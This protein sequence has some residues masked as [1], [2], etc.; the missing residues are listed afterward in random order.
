MKRRVVPVSPVELLPLQL[1]TI[2]KHTEEEI[3][4]TNPRLFKHIFS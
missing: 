3:A 4:V 1:E 2:G